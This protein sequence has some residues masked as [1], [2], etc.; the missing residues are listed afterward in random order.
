M[1]QTCSIIPDDYVN[2]A[3][4]P[5]AIAR[6]LRG[7]LESSSTSVLRSFVNRERPTFA[8]VEAAGDLLAPF[9]GPVEAIRSLQKGS[10]LAVQGPP[11]TGKTRLAAEALAALMRDGKRVAVAAPGHATIA[12]CLSKALDKIDVT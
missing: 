10:V 1:P 5:A 3:P 7:L 6:N 9:D 11:G 2:P 4:L 12:H 8:G